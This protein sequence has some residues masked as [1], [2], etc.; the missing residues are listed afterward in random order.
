MTRHQKEMI[1]R[2]VDEMY[3]PKGVTYPGYCVL[4]FTADGGRFY[5]SFK[6][7]DFDVS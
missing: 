5:S 3:Y 4:M 1:W 2:T 6:S 7:C